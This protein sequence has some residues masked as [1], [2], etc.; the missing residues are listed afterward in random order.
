MTKEKIPLVYKV[1]L[2]KMWKESDFGKLKFHSARI[3]MH[4]FRMGKE[5][6]KDVIAELKDLG[7]VECMGPHTIKILIP[8][9]DLV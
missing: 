2:K 7:Y 1:I 4:Q 6:S 5:N 9:K 3:I 8:L